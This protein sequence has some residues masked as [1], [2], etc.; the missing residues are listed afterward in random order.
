M[1]AQGIAAVVVS[2]Q[3]AETLD[4]CLTR[5]R[6]A[7]DIA[8]IRVVD[9]ASSDGSVEILVSGP[10]EAVNEL[11]RRCRRGPPAARVERVEVEDSGEGR[12]LVRH[13]SGEV[14]PLAGVGATSST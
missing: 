12:C 14:V 6:A 7:H 2:Y 9:N 4:D 13:A 10:D 1:N 11:V 5:L 8:E 3:S